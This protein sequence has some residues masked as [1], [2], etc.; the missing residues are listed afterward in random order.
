MMQVCGHCRLPTREDDSLR[1]IQI[2]N[3]GTCQVC[4]DCV[5]DEMGLPR[6]VIA[7]P[8]GSDI[9]LVG[10]GLA[11]RPV[12]VC[13]LCRQSLR[14][15][16]NDAH[17]RLREGDSEQFGEGVYSVCQ[18]CLARWKPVILERRKAEGAVPLGTT[19]NTMSRHALL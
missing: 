18:D 8:V 4:R 10:S 7:Y 6:P 15:E 13:G 3:A 12:R 16:E 14:F 5:A 11:M 9:P 1:T 19:V 17:I 2:T